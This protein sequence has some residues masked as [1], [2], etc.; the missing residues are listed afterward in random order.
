MSG[1]QEEVVKE[2]VRE[3]YSP[4]L[5]RIHLLIFLASIHD[6]YASSDIQSENDLNH[7]IGIKRN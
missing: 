5:S 1:S 7:Q 6:G 3:V 4:F 2:F